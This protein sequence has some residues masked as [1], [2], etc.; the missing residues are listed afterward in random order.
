MLRAGS[1]EMLKRA[2]SAVAVA[3]MVGLGAG[4]AQADNL[5]DA[6][7]GA[8]K[9][10]GLL[11]QNRA[12][13]RA[14]DEDVAIAVSGLRPVVDFILQA[15]RDLTRTGN[16]SI[17]NGTIG[18]STATAAVTM[19]WLLYNNGA[20]KLSVEAAKET[21]LATR[22]Q[23]VQVE[24][25]V[26]LRAAAAYFGWLLQQDNVNLRLNNLKLLQ[27][28][29]RAAQD[30]FDVGEVTRTDVAL[31]ESQVAA[32][33][34]S[35]AAASGALVSAQAEYQSAVGNLPSSLAGRP[36]LP[37]APRSIDDAEAVA[38][39][40][41]PSL[42]AAQH[43]VKAA[44]LTVQQVR[45][46]QGFALST[47]LTLSRT[48]AMNTSA[49][50][51]DATLDLTLSKRLYQGGGMNA[52]LRKTMASRDSTRGNLLTVQRDVIQN[53][54]D[55]FVSLQSA[56][57]S[58]AASEEQVRAAQVAF[59]GIREEATLGART[60]LDVLSAEQELLDAHTAVISARTDQEI[61]AYS[62]LSS[63]GLL[64]AERLKLGVEIYDPA[65][66]YNMAKTAPAQIS[67]QSKD[68][69][70]VL[71]ALGKN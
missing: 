46:S 33:R 49:Y 13:L 36:N 50:S 30:R 16:N 22:Q 60:T 56:Q 58:L 63:Q 2:V 65:L 7:V 42:L 40:N 21:V 31:A 14:A 38:L 51:D 53:V 5:A 24:Q 12:L 23:L 18:T 71:K 48:D 52:Q 25:Q 45:A 68:L 20:T 29:L 9:T 28:E 70:R 59:D 10:S 44:E 43:Q 11:D 4:A 26:L 1:R 35:L 41:H 32:A 37:A 47:G 19:D 54:N 61:A 64:T 57:A 34:S 55:A 17:R 69:D 3:A 15:E 8:Y 62:L 66:Y 67:K 27:E 6:M 39:R